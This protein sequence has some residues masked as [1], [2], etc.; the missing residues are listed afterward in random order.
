MKNFFAIV[1]ATLWISI[2]EFVRN[3]WL[4][5]HFWVDHYADLGL[6]FPS[7]PINGMV[8]GVWSLCLALGIFFLLK[9]FTF[10]Q[11]VGIAWWMG[12]VMMWLVTGNMMVLPF[13]ILLYAIPLSVLEV[14]LAAGIL[15]KLRGN[16][17]G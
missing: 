7:S 6:H 9:R 3:E 10:L 15:L 13:A 11:S 16:P 14:A 1:A 12:F 4:L 2:S 17:S 8:W 5:K